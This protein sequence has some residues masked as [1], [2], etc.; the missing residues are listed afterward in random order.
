MKTKILSVDP[1]QLAEFLDTFCRIKGVLHVRNP[2]DELHK[3]FVKIHKTRLVDFVNEFG[4]RARLQEVFEK[5]APVTHKATA[6]EIADF[7]KAEKKL[8][9]WVKQ[10]EETGTDPATLFQIFGLLG[11]LER[12]SRK[13]SKKAKKK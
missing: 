1:S 10:R 6:K 11:Q 5:L 12:D 8:K 4:P 2:E 9:Q 7:K 3:K 13:T